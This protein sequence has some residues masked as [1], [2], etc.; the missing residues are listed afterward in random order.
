MKKAKFKLKL[1]RSL[2]HD[3]VNR[4]GKRGT[5]DALE[6]LAEVS[7]QQ[8]PIDTGALRDSACVVTVG[9]N[10]SEGTV[11]Y[12]MPYAIVQHENTTFQHPHG[13]KAKYL[14]DPCYSSAVQGEMVSLAADAFKQEMG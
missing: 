1:D 14:E 4:C 2:I 3:V 12:N 8:V 10:G 6:H 13:R 9:G 7:K 5:L 11:S